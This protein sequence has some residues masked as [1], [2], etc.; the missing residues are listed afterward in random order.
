[1]VLAGTISYP[2]YL[3]HEN[4]MVALTITTHRWLPFIP[5]ALTPWP[6]I[7]LLGLIAFGI[8]GTLEPSLRSL[9]KKR[10]PAYPAPT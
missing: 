1:M 3:I 10:L 5:G 7:V 8:A 2:F 9:I 4:A 6:G